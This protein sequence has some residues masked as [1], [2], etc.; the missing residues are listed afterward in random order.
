MS[1]RFTDTNK[2][3]KPFIRGL[4]GPYKVLWDYLYHDCDHAGVWIVD[5]EIAQIY[6]GE[7]MPVNKEDALKYFNNGEIRIIELHEGSK[8]FIPPFIEFQY[9]ELNENNRAH[10]S[11]I[12]ILKKYNLLGRL[13]KPLRSPLEG[14]KDKDK[15]KDMVKSIEILP[16]FY[17]IFLSW[18]KYK[19]TRGESYKNKIS[20][21]V[22][23]KN[24]LEFSNESPDKAIKVVEQSIGNNWAGLFGLKEELNKLQNH[25]A[26]IKIFHYIFL[27]VLLLLFLL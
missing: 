27:Q 21:K 10:N 5:F 23:Y 18:L 26:L 7:D 22:A 25:L 17:D 12:T 14:G 9:G 11:V 8:W 1:K 3:K 2:Y 6:I 15:D 4:E 20:A 24:L 13:N 19:R 16:E